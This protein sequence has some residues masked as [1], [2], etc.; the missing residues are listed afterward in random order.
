MDLHHGDS[1]ATYTR[2]SI[3]FIARPTSL[4]TSV[5]VFT[6]Y[7]FKYI[8]IM[9]ISQM[10]ILLHR[11]MMLLFLLFISISLILYLRYFLILFLKCLLAS[12]LTLFRL[13]PF[14]SLGSCNYCNSTCFLWSNNFE[15]P[16]SKH[17]VIMSLMSFY[18]QVIVIETSC[19]LCQ[20]QAQS[21]NA[22]IDDFRAEIL[23]FLLFGYWQ[24]LC[25][26]TVVICAF[27]MFMPS[28]IKC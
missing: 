25:L 22:D 23:I 6:V 19:V 8:H 21:L 1:R 13:S 20:E 16:S 27:I 7:I 24:E 5:R 2:F 28:H 4:L 9:S 10:L 11:S 17:G 26:I 12:R 18:W 3:L 14:I 15:H